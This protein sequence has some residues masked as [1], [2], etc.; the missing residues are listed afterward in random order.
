MPKKKPNNEPKGDF[1]PEQRERLLLWC[2][3]HCC[4]CGEA[5]DVLIDVHHIVPRAD[6]GT[7]DDDNA[8]PLCFDCHGK[9]GHYNAM[10]P[11]GNRFRESE[12][13]K[14]REQVYDQ[15][16]RHL[17][18]RLHLR[19]TGAPRQLPNVGFEAIHPGGAPAV[20]LAVDL[21]AWAD[22]SRLP[23]IGDALYSGGPRWNLNPGDG[24]AGH[25]E[26]DGRALSARDIRIVVEVTIV[27]VY[28]RPHKR[29]PV[30]WVYDPDRADWWFD[31]VG[32]DVVDERIAERFKPGRTIK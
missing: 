26:V 17:V 20:Q 24:V 23:W 10:H 6:G 12:L 9:V 18:P 19:V 30:S 4:L 3:R 29:L 13:K 28:A 5:C 16:T 31:P 32:A 22:G 7:N 25:F 8:I 21:Q 14:R 15:H 11:K 2:A 27:D 1:S